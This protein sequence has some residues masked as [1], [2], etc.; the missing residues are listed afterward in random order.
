MIFEIFI[1]KSYRFFFLSAEIDRREK[2]LLEEFESIEANIGLSKNSEKDT[3]ASETQES[4]SGEE[5][6]ENRDPN[7]DPN[8]DLSEIHLPDSPPAEDNEAKNVQLNLSAESAVMNN[9]MFEGEP[10]IEG[11]NDLH[12]L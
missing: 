3:I 10:N 6:E 7:P 12:T 9:L 2:E 1:G 5:G 8:G 11:L 4:K